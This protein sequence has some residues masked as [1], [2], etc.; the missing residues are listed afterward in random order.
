M[1][2]VERPGR[3]QLAALAIAAA[4]VLQIVEILAILRGVPPD[5]MDPCSLDLFGLR[6]PPNGDGCSI[7][8][9][10]PAALAV[11][12]ILFAAA[13][14]GRPSGLAR[15]GAAI[16]AAAFVLTVPA[17]AAQFDVVTTTTFQA[18][19]FGAATF[20][21]VVPDRRNATLGRRFWIVA[22]AGCIVLG[23]LDFMFSGFL[24]ATKP[25]PQISFFI[26]AAAIAGAGWIANRLQSGAPA[27]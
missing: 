2:S 7:P 10:V 15:L 24:Y 8:V 23:V 14:V 27:A 12:T 18:A 5:G 6:V 9:S 3:L 11:A 4:G 20:L 1:T 25:M 16:A 19:L 22:I 21:I 26:V 17:V 13:L